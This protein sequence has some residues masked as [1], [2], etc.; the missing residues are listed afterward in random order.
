VPATCPRT[1]VMSR[2][3]QIPKT[4]TNH[5]TAVKPAENQQSKGANRSGL[6]RTCPPGVTRFVGWYRGTSKLPMDVTIDRSSTGYGTVAPG[7]VCHG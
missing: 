2:S 7:K 6:F 3:V 4:M 1:A 5:T